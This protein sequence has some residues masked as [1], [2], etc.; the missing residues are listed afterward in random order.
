LL[1]SVLVLSHSGPAYAPPSPPSVTFDPNGGSGSM[2]IQEGDSPAALTA[3]SFTRA[4]Y[5][6]SGWNTAESGLGTAYGDQ[7][8]YAFSESTTLFAQWAQS[9]WE[10]SYYPSGPQTNVASSAVTAGGWELC[11]SGPYNGF[12][13]FS[14]I[15]GPQPSWLIWLGRRKCIPKLGCY[16]SWIVPWLEPRNHHFFGAVS[17]DGQRS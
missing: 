14:D 11:W 13:K 15:L 3:N 12:A 9:E 6:F 2:E 7:A 16:R 1:A 10:P 17:C 5:R 8:S 4:G